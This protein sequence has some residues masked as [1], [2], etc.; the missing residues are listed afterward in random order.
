MRNTL[1][2]GIVPHIH[3]EAVAPIAFGRADCIDT[4]G[5][6]AYFSSKKKETSGSA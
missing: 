5:F 3:P 1:Q 6:A 4:F 2:F